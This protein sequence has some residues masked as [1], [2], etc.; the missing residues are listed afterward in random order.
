MA[1]E[2]SG[3]GRRWPQRAH[4]FF[5]A[6]F[7]RW[8]TLVAL[9]LGA[10]TLLIGLGRNGLWEPWEMDR[11]D[12]AR[13]LA[14]P[15]EAVV[16]LGAATS[17]AEVAALQ[18]A[19]QSVGVAV[20]RPDE[21]PTTALRATLD[22]ARARIVA[23]IVIDSDLLLPDAARDDLWRQAGKL[24]Q[25]ALRY[26]AGGRVV[27][28]RRDRAPAAAELAQRLA[29]ERARDTWETAASA[30]ALG[31]AWDTSKLEEALA[32]V[33]AEVPDT[34]FVVVEAADHAALATA[35]SDGASAIGM[36]V[37]FKDRG[38]L[39]AVAPLETWLRAAAYGVF[40]PSELSTRLPGVILCFIAFWVLVITT[41]SVWG[42]RVALISG[43]VL[44]TTPLFFAQARIISGEPSLILATSL[45]GSAFLLST[46]EKVPS[47]LVWGYLIAGLLAG[48]LG[49]G[50]FALFL[51]AIMALAVPLTRGS[52]RPADFAP[53][54]MFLLAG[55]LTQLIASSASPAS[56][57]AGLDFNVDLFSEGPS[58]YSKTFDIV[59]RDLGFGMA[60]WSP[61]VAVAV[62]LLVFSSLA[63]RDARGLV[64]SVWFFVP[65]FAVMASIKVGNHFLFAGV[66][67]AAISVGL[68]VDRLLRRGERPADAPAD[69]ATAPTLPPKYFIALALVIMFYILRRELKPGP[70]P[71]V[72]FLAYDPPF[73]REG[74]LRFPETVPFD[75]TFKLVFILTALA[76][77][78]HFGRVASLGLTALRWLRKTGPFLV[79]TGV[80]ALV[81]TLAALIAAGR[82]HGLGM[83][84]AYSDTIRNT[85]RALAGRLVGITDPMIVVAIGIAALVLGVVIARWMFPE[86]GRAFGPSR[87]RLRR[88]E[89]PLVLAFAG[90]WV[91]AFI[92]AVFSVAAPGGYVAEL[93]FSMTGALALG[94]ALLIGGIAWL[95]SRR[96]SEP[97]ALA[98]ASLALV[99][100]TQLVRD[101]SLSS[102]PVAIFIALG[103]VVAALGLLPRLLEPVSHFLFA[104]C[105]ALA[106]IGLHYVA[107]LVDRGA[108]VAEIVYAT[109][110]ANG[111]LSAASAARPGLIFAVPVLTL[112]LVLNWALPHL[113][114]RFAGPEPRAARVSTTLRDLAE[115]L[116][117]W[118][119]HRYVA[120]SALVLLALV[121]SATHILRL[122]PAIAVN[123]SQ[124]HILDTW[125]GD[126]THG[127][128]SMYKHGSFAA[129][130]GRKDS[131]FYTAD[132]P[133]IRDRQAALR[134]LLG[135]E[136]QVLDVETPLGTETR[137]IPGFSPANDKDGD[138]RRDS[139]AI[140]GFASAVTA[141]TLTDAS[142]SWAP[143]SL[144]GRTLSDST[145][146]TW[147]IVDNDATSVTVGPGDRLSFALLPRS[148][149]FYVID[150][151]GLD[152]RATG[153]TPVRR[154]VL[155]PADQLS[156]LNFA[157]RQLS[158]G[159]HLPVL[160]GTSYRVLLT[161]SWLE[162]GEPQ[163]NRL[164]LATY[165]D[166]T[167]AALDD[168]RLRRVW[169]TFDD[170]IQL[171]GYS[172]DKDI[173]GTGSKLRLTL[174]FKTLKLV[175]RSLK[176]FIHM[177]KTG[178]GSRIQGDHWPLNPT[179]HTEEN[180]NCNGCYRTDHWL[181]GDIVADSYEIEIPEGNTG[182]YM[183]WLGLFQP[184]PDT[185]AV[186][187]DWDKKNAR[188]DGGNRLGIGTVRVK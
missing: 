6:L 186:V 44:A 102:A 29:L 76:L 59:V 129:A 161:T 187:R 71:L 58:L 134:V 10:A 67:A 123:V 184:G 174:Y 78:V 12:L 139:P 137:H 17:D 115:R 136:D 143:R 116:V 34:D 119:Q 162:E 27:V 92:V 40:G 83:G 73:A 86:V 50:A 105:L 109:E 97:L 173:V 158:G 33:A 89:T 96:W 11:A 117:G 151:P 57:W 22:I 60:P 142:Q 26:V 120:V 145:G 61:V 52:R 167:F 98:L 70:E 80:V 24:S 114:A 128:D 90:L 107:V 85:Q 149:A 51:F 20:K 166:Q 104:S 133:E 157:W 72:A 147:A 16:A 4:A 138:A 179:R 132:I 121:G 170:T 140:T 112:A 75:G 176:I 87:I 113:I 148:R 150:A 155:L 64:V 88:I 153:T 28:L 66:G 141:T 2:S 82:V 99:L 146:R 164:A 5:Q 9:A 171:V 101:A 165:T 144:V 39:K 25:E 188:H 91:V 14:N 56:F 163:Q 124:K 31:S 169:G 63:S 74:N 54:A 35:L 8:G 37:A 19:G 93:V 100:T 168:P 18:Q 118:A 103:L 7:G 42:P 32:A 49:K 53:A 48:G 46:L 21:S 77:F 178:G 81:T 13:T 181:V 154:A 185:R 62:G 65:V 125:F 111:T 106:L 172:T 183:I 84:S 15:P 30:Y 68:F 38:E 130:Q 55:V 94:A 23:A 110:I 135:R 95:V 3:Q 69:P 156:E 160:D 47:R 108:M 182:E 41:R 175:K 177:D 1:P 122:E 36:R 79:T 159:R 43:F 127:P 45:V 152:P 180:K 131:N 126:T